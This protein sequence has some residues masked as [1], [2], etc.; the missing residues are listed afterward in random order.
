MPLRRNEYQLCECHQTNELDKFIFMKDLK[1]GL[2]IS[3]LVSVLVIFGCQYSDSKGFLKKKQEIQR[4]IV[5]PSFPEKKFVITDFGAIRGKE[6][7][8]TKAIEAAIES[9]HLAGGGRVVVPADTFLT[10]AIHL[11]SNV[12]LYL[13]EGAVLLFSINPEDYLPM[14]FTRWEGMEL[15]NYSPLIYA[16]EQENVAITGKGVLD[17][18]ASNENWWYWCGSKRFGWNE[19]FGRQNQARDSLHIL[20]RLEVP[21]QQ[22][23]F[24]RGHYLRPNFVQFYK[25]QNIILSDFTIVNSPMWVLHPV[26]S[27]NITIQRLTIKSLGP[28]SDGCDPESCKNV[29]I[30]DC[31]F[32]TGDDC[33]AIKSGRD[34]DGRRIGIPSENIIIENCVMKRGH[35]GVVIGSEVS[36]GCRNVFALNCVMDSPQLDRALRIKTSSSRGGIIENVYFKNIQVGTYNEAAIKINMFYEAPGNFLPVVRNIFVENLKVND[37]GKYG[38]L[39]RAYKESPVENF[40]MKNCTINSV[41]HI[42]KVDFVNKLKINNVVIN[43]QEIFEDDILKD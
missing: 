35:G 24:G 39:I 12:N 6:R 17:G 33:I 41:D 16:F 4:K 10:G 26:L 30:K 2:L 43:G 22:R 14:V 27:E 21:P 9:C 15:M 32:D 36:G 25:C 28:N 34:Q 3:C 31:F 23:I 11:K 42:A 19:G 40:V 18:Q 29:L 1:S 8:S 5:P 7:L 13:E 38:I 37:G 20:N